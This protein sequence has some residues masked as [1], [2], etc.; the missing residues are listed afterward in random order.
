MREV[1]HELKIVPLIAI[2]T[3][4]LYNFRLNDSHMILPMMYHS[5]VSA[6]SAYSTIAGFVSITDLRGINFNIT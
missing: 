2:D 1:I 3:A 6:I 4:Q 5:S